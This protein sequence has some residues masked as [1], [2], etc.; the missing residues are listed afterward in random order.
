MEP[1][2]GC[3]DVVL[4]YFHPDIKDVNVDDV[5]TYRVKKQECGPVGLR[6]LHR[7]RD[8]V[9]GSD[10]NI[11]YRMQGDAN[12]L[13]DSCLVPYDWIEDKFVAVI[14]QAAVQQAK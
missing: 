10:G 9:S 5:V 2:I 1:A 7:V 3:N 14:K 12:D 11:R 13:P 8:V 4:V 6:I